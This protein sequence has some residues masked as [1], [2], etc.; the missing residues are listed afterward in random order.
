MEG[1]KITYNLKIKPLLLLIVCICFFVSASCI[2]AADN[3]TVVADDEDIN[4]DEADASPTIQLE[5]TFQ[6]SYLKTADSVNS[7]SNSVD[8]TYFESE[9]TC[10]LNEDKYSDYGVNGNIY[11][12]EVLKEGDR[13]NPNGDD[14]YINGEFLTRIHDVLDGVES[15][16]HELPDESF[17]HEESLT[18][19]HSDGVES[20]RHE[21]PDEYYIYGALKG[22]HNQDGDEYSSHDFGNVL[23]LDSSM[24]VN[25][26]EEISDFNI[27]D[28]SYSDLTQFGCM[29]LDANDL[30]SQD[31]NIKD[32]NL[33]FYMF[34]NPDII[35]KKA[36]IISLDNNLQNLNTL[37]FKTNFNH[38]LNIDEGNI[39]LISTFSFYEFLGCV[40]G[41]NYDHSISIFTKKLFRIDCISNFSEEKS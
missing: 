7:E 29:D 33:E 23:L 18:V 3:D 35:I 34:S 25:Q 20:Q 32:Y 19:Y 6:N 13:H 2:Y 12:N 30:Y 36:N 40:N 21:L 5:K 15:Q 39:Y 9:L 17:N 16:R 4:I 26:V 10:G 28:L 22:I 38:C 41:D 11:S 8:E 14:S 27:S 31:L 1:I 37:F 24:I